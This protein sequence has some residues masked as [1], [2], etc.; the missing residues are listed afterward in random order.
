MRRGEEMKK[1]VNIKFRPITLFRS[2]SV[3]SLIIVLREVLSQQRLKIG[4]LQNRREEV[5][6]NN[7]ELT[8]DRGSEP[9]CNRPSESATSGG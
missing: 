7:E 6:D 8:G 1:K 4:V 9:D 3:L 5:D 2:S